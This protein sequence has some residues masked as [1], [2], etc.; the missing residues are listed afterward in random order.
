MI[1]F[2]TNIEGT[3]S[4]HQVDTCFTVHESY[5]P[6]DTESDYNI[7]MKERQSIPTLKVL[8]IAQLIMDRKRSRSRNSFQQQQTRSDFIPIH[9]AYSWSSW[10]ASVQVETRREQV[11]F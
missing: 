5:V 7:Q 3:L 2:L 8:H 4:A 11:S 1:N 9:I 10:T 6:G